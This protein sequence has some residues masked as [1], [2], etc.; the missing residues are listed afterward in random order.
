M[1]EEL[2]YVISPLLDQFSELHDFRLSQLEDEIIQGLT[3]E[4]RTVPAFRTHYTPDNE[5]GLIVI[6][7]TFCFNLTFF[8]SDCPGD[9]YE[10]EGVDVL[11]ENPLVYVPNKVNLPPL[12]AEPEPFMGGGARVGGFDEEG[13]PLD[14]DN[15]DIFF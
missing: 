3:G 10:G 2:S 13:N 5:G 15:D 11:E 4:L 1:T 14:E 8:M 12:P 9:R 6:R 7:F